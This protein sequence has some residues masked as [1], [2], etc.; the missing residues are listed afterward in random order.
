MDA[1]AYPMKMPRPLSI[2]TLAGRFGGFLAKAGWRG[3]SEVRLGRCCRRPLNPTIGHEQRGIRPC[4][5]VSDPEVIDDQRFPLICVVP[6]TGTPDEGI[7]YPPL[8]PWQR[9]ASPRRHSR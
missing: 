7:L 6:V 1:A 5:V 9:A 3:A 4:I 8:G 2:A